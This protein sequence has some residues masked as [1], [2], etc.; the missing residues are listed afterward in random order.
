MAPL[1][2]RQL[3]DVKRG[4]RSDSGIRDSSTPICRTATSAPEATKDRPS[5]LAEATR[6]VVEFQRVRQ[7]R[8]QFDFSTKVSRQV[9]EM[10]WIAKA[11]RFDTCRMLLELTGLLDNR[12]TVDRLVPPGRLDS[13]R[14]S[15]VLERL[16]LAHLQAEFV[17]LESDQPRRSTS[18]QPSLDLPITYLADVII[19]SS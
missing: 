18:W 5:H 1:A 15:W 4:I 14:F 2:Y 11:M 10:S 8:R 19:T 17:S 16:C 6:L 7:N 9:H 3:A 13:E 12:P